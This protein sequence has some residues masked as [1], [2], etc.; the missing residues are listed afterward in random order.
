MPTAP[1]ERRNFLRFIGQWL[2]KAEDEWSG[3]TRAYLHK[4]NKVH[5]SKQLN[6]CSDVGQSEQFFDMLVVETYAPIRRL[7]SDLAR[8]ARAMNTVILP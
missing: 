4:S 1:A 7:P 3:Y 5:E 6:L 8:V 2:S